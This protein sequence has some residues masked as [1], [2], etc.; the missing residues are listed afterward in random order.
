MASLLDEDTPLML[1][2]TVCLVCFLFVLKVFALG[3]YANYTHKNLW[4]VLL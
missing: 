1:S 2:H 3:N 4:R